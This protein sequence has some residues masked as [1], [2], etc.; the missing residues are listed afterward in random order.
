KRTLVHR[1]VAA[2]F[3]GPRPPD[4]IVHHKDHNKRNNLPGNLEYVTPSENIKLAYAD[5]QIGKSY[6]LTAFARAKAVEMY[7]TGML[8]SKVAER[9]RVSK[10]TILLCV[11]RAG[12]K[13]DRN[14]RV[15]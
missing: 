13:P 5:G 14:R 6:K 15:R 1:L 8:T 2:A 4:K 3:L 11:R 10:D 12:I 7:E 9:F